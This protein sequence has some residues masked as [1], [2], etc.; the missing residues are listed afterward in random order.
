MQSNFSL[1]LS[2]V[3]PNPQSRNAVRAQA[4]RSL[5]PT[6][7]TGMARSA[8]A[9]QTGSTATAM[10]QRGPVGPEAAL[11]TSPRLAI[12]ALRAEAARLRQELTST[13][14]RLEGAQR[15]RD[16]FA[17]RAEQLAHSLQRAET[18]LRRINEAAEN[19]SHTAECLVTQLQSE[20]LAL[21]QQLQRTW[22]AARA[23]S[24]P[25]ALAGLDVPGWPPPRLPLRAGTATVAEPSSSACSAPAPSPA[26]LG[27]E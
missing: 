26:E 15:D 24:A 4:S 18:E 27:W 5:E 25:A 10:G 7:P 8:S 17:R 14:L 16:L 19:L 1:P 21:T 6:R 13:R 23:A 12:E 9:P 3:D 2:S 22:Q 20:R 11:P